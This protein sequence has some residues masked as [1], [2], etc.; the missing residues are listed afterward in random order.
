MIKIGTHK[1]RY[2]HDAFHRPW[3]S[4]ALLAR[5]LTTRINA[6]F[7][8]SPLWAPLPFPSVTVARADSVL[9]SDVPTICSCQTEREEKLISASSLKMFALL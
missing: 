1:N 5:G 7:G 3:T 9:A 4:S 8:P 2:S 6:L